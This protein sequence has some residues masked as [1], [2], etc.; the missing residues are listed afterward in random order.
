MTTIPCSTT[1]AAVGEGL[2]GSAPDAVAWV[3]LEQN[4]PWGKKAFTDSHLDAGLGRS[5][6]EL[7]GAHGVRPSLVRR[8]GRHADVTGSDARTVL[9]GYTHPSG[10]WLLAGTVPDPSALLSLDWAAVASGARDLALASL[11]GLAPSAPV[12]LVCT[13]GTRDTCCARL[14]RPIAHA[15]AASHPERVWEVT[16][17]S[18]HRFAPTTVLLPYGVLHG[19]VL[20]AAGILDAADRGEL[21][22]HGYRGRSTWPSLGQVAEAEVRLV[23]GITGLDDLTVTPDA[24]GWCV[25][26]RDGRRWTVSVTSYE[27]GVRPPSCGKADEPVQRFVAAIS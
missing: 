5:I 17:T 19:R 2:A 27:E 4:G 8:P 1:S 26:H 16:H 18:G 7:A 25:R 14:G 6:E 23:A 15:A 21:L 20:D 10:T 12:L 22:E 3:C 24:A 13:N 11:P 9:V